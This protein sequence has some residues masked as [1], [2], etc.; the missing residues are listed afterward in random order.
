[1]DTTFMSAADDHVVTIPIAKVQL[2]GNLVVPL[3]AQGLV[4]LINGSNGRYNPRNY[5]STHLLRRAGLA[6]LLVDLLTP[7]EVAMDVRAKHFYRDMNLLA[8]RLVGVTDWLTQVEATG[9]F[10]IGYLGV[11]VSGGAALAAAAQRQA[12][13]GAV[14]CQSSEIDQVNAILP[15]VQAPTLL[16]IGEQDFP[17][18]AA[19]QDAM[20]Q[21][22]SEK[23]LVIVPQATHLF[24]EPGALEESLR[25][26]SL[27]FQRYLPSSTTLE[28]AYC[29]RFVDRTAPS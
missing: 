14:V 16:I 2:T 18:R 28:Q 29:D 23:Q 12:T 15:D 4:V 27:W 1:M 3:E 11:G 7:E 10:K 26:A 21:L 17:V 13:I 5:Y 8:T 22:K 6:T 25:L 9:Q 19:H 24:K 20:S